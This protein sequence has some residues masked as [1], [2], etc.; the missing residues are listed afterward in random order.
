MNLAVF[1]F[2]KGGSRAFHAFGRWL[3]VQD[4]HKDNRSYQI[5]DVR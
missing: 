5:Y 1:S 2:R 4:D 3:L